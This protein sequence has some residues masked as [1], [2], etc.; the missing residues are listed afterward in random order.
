MS[1][2]NGK[3]TE[4]LIVPVKC[5][6]EQGTA[7]FI[8]RNQLVTARHVVREHFNNPSAP[9]PIFVI[10][11]GK[12]LTCKAEELGGSA[13]VAILTI[14][15]DESFEVS[16]WLILLKDHFVPKLELT[17][18]GYP[19]EVA[20]GV[21]LVSLSV[22]NR[23]EVSNWNDRTLVRLDNLK[24]FNYDGLSGS[25]VV[26]VEGR[27][28]GILTL[29]V[30]ETLGYLSI[31]KISSLLSTKGVSYAEDWQKEDNTTFGQGRS[32]DLCEKAVAS[33]H[34]RYM[35]GLH[36]N[37]N[38]LVLSLKSMSDKKT[39]DE[40]TRDANTLVDFIDGIGKKKLSIIMKIFNQPGSWKFD[41]TTKKGIEYL[42]LF[43]QYAF[44]DRFKNILSWNEEIQFDR[45]V[46]ILRDGYAFDY[47][48]GGLTKNL[49]LIG[50]A[51]SG[52][53][54][55]LCDFATKNQELANIYLFF[56]TEFRP[57]ESV[58]E[59]I[60]TVIC[61]KDS[62]ND[63]NIQMQKNGR[64][65][66]IIIDA[67]NEGLGCTY[68]NNQL[69]ALRKELSKYDHIKLVVS[70]RS[71][72]N[73]ELSDLTSRKSGWKI[74]EVEGFEDVDTAINKFFEEYGIPK[75]YKNRKIEAFRN[76]LFLKIFC[77]TFYSMSYS[78]RTRFSKRIIYKKY[79]EKKN[80]I[81]SH[82]VDEDLE[83]NV[84]DKYLMKLANYS[85]NNNHFN[86][87]TRKKARE[88]ARRICP[89]RLWSNDLLNAML[90]SNL[91]LED[92]STKDDAAVMFEYE[93]LGDYYKAEQLLSPKKDV[94]NVL[95][96][97]IG[98]K[99][100]YERNP[101]VS[102]HKFENAIIALYDC[103]N[104]QGANVQR[105]VKL[106]KN[107]FLR[108]LYISYLLNSDL[109]Y[110]AVL[111]LLT[112]LDPSIKQD[113]K[114]LRA[115]QE[116]SLTKTLTIHKNLLSY[117]T[118]AKRDL[119]WTNFV[120]GMF[121]GYG[122]SIIQSPLHTDNSPHEL[123]DEIKAFLI[124][125]GWLLTTSHPKYR[126]L[127]IRCLRKELNSCKAAITWLLEL[128]ANVNDPYVLQGLFCA[129]A[130]VVL[131]SRNKELAGS[132]AEYVYKTYYQHR[133]TVPQDLIVRQ[134]S[135]KI[136][137]RAYYL[138]NENNKWW[139][140]IE[141]PFEALPFD[142]AEIPLKR[143]I[144]RGYFG[145]QHG[146]Q[147]MYNSIFGFEDF[148]RYIIGNNNRLR[149]SDYFKYNLIS[150]KYEGDDLDR[151]EA[152]L[153]YYIKNVFG[154]NDKLGFLDNGKYSVN[155]SHNDEERIGK[156][157]QWLAWYRL[158]ARLMD[159]YKVTKSPFYFSQ[160]AKKEDITPHPY[161]WNS[162]EVS[163]FDPTL[164]VEGYKKTAHLLKGLE[165]S[166]IIGAEDIEWVQKNDYVPVFR[167]KAAL[168]DGTPYVMLRGFDKAQQDDK[169][170]VVITNAVFIKR[171]DAEGFEK[172]C[173]T[174]NFYGRWMPERNGM[175]EFLWNDY[176]WADAYKNAL[177]VKS[178][179]RPSNGCPCDVM[180]AYEAQLQEH[181]EGIANEDEYL[182]TV[183]MPCSDL[184]E[185]A[186]LYC[187]E[188]RGIVKADSDNSIA[189]INPSVEEG[190]TG[191]FIRKDILDEY[192]RKNDYILFYYVLGEKLLYIE[193][194]HSVMK[195]LSA[196]YKYN[197]DG[198]VSE[199]QAMRVIERE[200]PKPVKASLEKILA[201]RKKKE[202]EGLTSREVIELINMEQVLEKKNEKDNNN[203]SEEEG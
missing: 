75:E 86:V 79:V 2:L 83:L 202:E 161:P 21:N 151:E 153:A 34:D 146:S 5:C 97:L 52:K 173:K 84:A 45:Y 10:V 177:E 127:I 142:E 109:D 191:L 48:N 3:V 24:L 103:W 72:F 136:V 82:L 16:E 166:D 192:L 165:A 46:N 54:H 105:N 22:I 135:L 15:D 128:F 184:M 200:S 85:V 133:E 17:V 104:E 102:S 9:E 29:Q 66:V 1:Y 67:L 170:T 181:W 157:F 11:E 87:V 100:Y 35:P 94:D 107:T 149:S 30:N 40:S 90:T 47:I 20:M 182:T 152:E 4:N 33:I 145:M 203:D 195:D 148:N 69:G 53:T 77:E 39:I 49:C 96:W 126:A 138:D 198:T 38:Q 89:Y 176:P 193:E 50:K 92:R 25:P 112:E 168:E 31:A 65:A 36:Q 186:G 37:N 8:G 56:G 175:Y 201:L 139:A 197:L 169:E 6:T 118:I 19:Q 81:V 14:L 172:W 78:E 27:V 196:A 137:E 190:M 80:V 158:N 88:Y 167:F 163:Y 120:N 159:S 180:L 13:D 115:P 116:L 76:P 134:W 98:E 106:Q 111:N 32:A 124:R 68:W 44:K 147:L 60:R 93:N 129:I 123:N 121:E 74:V 187:S 58:T 154:W 174:K 113:L 57:H 122:S 101:I 132:V 18:Y 185:K 59:H 199:L 164:D 28:I 95:E 189:A 150:D 162:S 55:N 91:L 7:F 71:P 131:P 140:Q 141:T 62:F 179:E 12:T 23:L 26:N 130:G 41:L 117:E 73:Q 188:V 155:R 63:L 64:Y 110:N 183:Y 143:D 160:E 61:E 114:L 125:L 51:G 119:L 171:A 108:E 70:V 43:C 178:W 156:K 144:D 42:E 99:K 194:F